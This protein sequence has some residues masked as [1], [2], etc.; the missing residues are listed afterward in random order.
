MEKNIL[1]SWLTVAVKAKVGLVF[2]HCAILRVGRGT[3]RSEHYFQLHTDR[4]YQR[5][6]L[7]VKFGEFSQYPA[8]NV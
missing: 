4:I 7:R 5:A 2:V 8:I 3:E 1:F 6:V